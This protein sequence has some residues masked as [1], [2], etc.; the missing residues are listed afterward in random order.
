MVVVHAGGGERVPMN[1]AKIQRDNSTRPTS[2]ACGGRLLCV[3]WALILCPLAGPAVGAD[4][5]T[6]TARDWPMFRG[7]STLTGVAKSRLPEKIAVRWTLECGEAITSSAAIVDGVVY[8]GSEDGVLF[9]VDLASGK[10]VWQHKTED[11]IHSSPTVYRG[12]VFYGDAAGIMHAV[13]AKTGSGRWKFTTNGEIISSVNPMGD[14]IFFGSYDGSLYALA[15]ADGKQIWKHE[16]EGRVHGTPGII[17]GRVIAAG[18]DEYLHVVDAASGKAIPSVTLGSVVGVAAAVD[19]PM[20]YLGTYGSRVVAI[21]WR[22]NKLVW[23][24]QDPDREF[25][26][27]SSAAISEKVIVLG[28]RDK[29][30]RALD[31]ATGKL[32]WSLRMRGRIDSSP[33]IVG[34]RVFV[35]ASDG[36][37]YEV[38]LTSG[39]ERWR[40]EAGAPISASPALADGCLVVGTEDGLLYC[41]SGE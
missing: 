40:Y 11:A 38:D 31:R 12:T 13:D 37:L 28:S 25:P 36:N 10:P 20:V 16:T 4:G 34:D 26:Y 33:V 19:G 9:A 23:E 14:R 17:D 1:V 35:G 7:G 18:C 6:A 39:R 30:L 32:R 41:F 3:G 24:F 29:T 8:V 27:M 15:A 5:L 2:R 22:A 21:D